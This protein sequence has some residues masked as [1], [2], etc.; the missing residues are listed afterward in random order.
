MPAMPT[1][2]P[3]ELLVPRTAPDTARRPGD[4]EQCSA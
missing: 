4:D 3:H 1:G 2:Q